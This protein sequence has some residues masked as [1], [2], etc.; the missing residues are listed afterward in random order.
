MYN[1]ITKLLSPNKKLSL[2]DE[3]ADCNRVKKAQVKL[4]P[5]FWTF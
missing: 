1:K 2:T 5:M 3:T 4:F